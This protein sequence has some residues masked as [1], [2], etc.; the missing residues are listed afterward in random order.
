[1]IIKIYN[2]NN[3]NGNNNI[4]NNNCCRSSRKCAEIFLLI[5]EIIIGIMK[6]IM[7]IKIYNQNNNNIDNRSSRKC[8]ETSIRSRLR[9]PSNDL[10]RQAKF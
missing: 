2:Q 1:M 7:I 3:N 4:D 5:M 9:P 8:A 10:I 6:E